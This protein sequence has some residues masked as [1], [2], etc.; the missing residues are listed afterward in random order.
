MSL[1]QRFVPQDTFAELSGFQTEFYAR[2]TGEAMPCC[3]RTVR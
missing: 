1:L 2:M 3:M